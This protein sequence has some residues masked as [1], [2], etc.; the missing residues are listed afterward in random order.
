[1]PESGSALSRTL[2]FCMPFLACILHGL[3]WPYLC[4]KN[5]LVIGGGPAGMQLRGHRGDAEP[6]GDACG[7]L[8]GQLAAVSTPAYKAQEIGALIGYLSTLVKKHGVEVKLSTEVGAQQG[9][10]VEQDE[11]C[12]GGKHVRSHAGWVLDGSG[13]VIG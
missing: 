4:L 11:G 12:E 9:N 8:G 3:G 10:R 7:E 6:Q 2:G 1:M 5:V 13:D